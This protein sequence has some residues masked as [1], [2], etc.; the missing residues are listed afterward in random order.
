MLVENF[1]Y[2]HL[3]SPGGAEY[4]VLEMVNQYFAPPRLEQWAYIRC[5]RHF[6]PL[7]HPPEQFPLIP[8]VYFLETSQLAKYE[9]NRAKWG[10]GTDDFMFRQTDIED[11]N[12]IK[13][14]QK[15]MYAYGMFDKDIFITVHLSKTNYT[16]SDSTAM[17]EILSSLV[18]K[19]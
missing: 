16:D 9:T 7:G 5:Y 17:S 4:V 6:A 8:F 18:K 12:G 19:K 1:R 13:M 14:K 15:H 2:H 10:E 11:F 3:L